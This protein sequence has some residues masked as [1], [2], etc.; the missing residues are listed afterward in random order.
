MAQSSSSRRN[1]NSAS[2]SGARGTKKVLSPLSIPENAKSADSG[3]PIKR[4]PH[5][6]DLY[7]AKEQ[8]KMSNAKSIHDCLEAID[9]NW[10]PL[11]NAKVLDQV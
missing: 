8:G 6:S 2:E 11:L 7:V 4:I 3:D 10:K 9:K 1:T 5:S